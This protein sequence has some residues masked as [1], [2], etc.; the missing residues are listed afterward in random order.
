VERKGL[1][2]GERCVLFHSFM[3]CVN[4]GGVCTEFT[5]KQTATTFWK[6]WRCDLGSV[7]VVDVGVMAILESLVVARYAKQKSNKKAGLPK[8]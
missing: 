5:K 4:Y 3:Q 1:L 7:R 2:N 6:R 8:Q